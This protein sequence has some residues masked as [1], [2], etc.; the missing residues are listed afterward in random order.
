MFEIDKERGER[1]ESGPCLR[2]KVGS[3]SCSPFLDP[4]PFFPPF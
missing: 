4:F 3:T 1:T 2:Y